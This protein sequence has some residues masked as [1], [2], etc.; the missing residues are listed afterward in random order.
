MKMF[1]VL[2][3]DKAEELKAKGFKYQE[4]KI[5]DTTVY[6]FLESEELVSYLNS[7]FSKETFFISKFMTF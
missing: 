2:E 6:T 5:G 4:N 3:K 1:N 7:N